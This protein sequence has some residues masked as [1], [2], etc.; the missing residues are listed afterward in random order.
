M[1]NKIMYLYESAGL[2]DDTNREIIAFGI[3]RLIDSVMSWL[4]AII[5]AWL[6]GDFLVG[7]IF[8]ACYMI[9]RR[10]AGGYHT[11]SKGSCLILTYLSTFICLCV[12]FTVPSNSILTVVIALLSDVVIIRYAPIQ[13]DNK[14]LNAM[15]R[16][17]YRKKTI[18]I[19]F[20]LT[21]LICIMLLSKHIIYAETVVVSMLLVMVGMV[22]SLPKR[23]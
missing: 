5:C 12:V 6:M 9:L 17:V 13:S 1:K 11:R 19:T 4:F 20:S 21:V 2:V 7:I 3:G 8:E 14:P 23:I 10:Y 15:E 18:C 22:V 16:K